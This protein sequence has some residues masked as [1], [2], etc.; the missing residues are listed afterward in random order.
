MKRILIGMMCA[1]MLLMTGVVNTNAAPKK[2]AE[3][4]DPADMQCREVTVIGIV[5]EEREAESKKERKKPIKYRVIT[6][7]SN[8][9]WHLPKLNKIPESINLS[10]FEGKKVKL[11][12]MMTG[13]KGAFVGIKSI[14]KVGD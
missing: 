10:E 13:N 14:E 1:G 2:K 6:D 11:V 9:E 3:A 12:G 5:S 4:K 7:S 8:K